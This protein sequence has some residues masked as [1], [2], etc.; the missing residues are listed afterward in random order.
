MKHSRNEVLA[1][2]QVSFPASWESVLAQLD[3]Y[4][5]ESHEPEQERVQLAVLKLGEGI[6]NKVRRFLAAAKDDYRDVLYW[7][8]YPGSSLNSR[9]VDFVSTDP[10]TGEVVLTISDHLAWEGTE[11]LQL[12]QEKLNTYLAF[13]E[14]RELV[15]SYSNA[16]GRPVRIDVVCKFPPPREAEQ[17]LTKAASVTSVAGFALS[18]RVFAAQEGAAADGPCPAGSDRDGAPS[19][20]D[21]ERRPHD[22]QS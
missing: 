3:T 8:E 5:V 1:A 18:W 11:H 13:I 4:G 21:I 20:G 7:A 10:A 2:V 16:K 22:A 9:V 12:L 19:L 15:E 17:F 14:S 6:E